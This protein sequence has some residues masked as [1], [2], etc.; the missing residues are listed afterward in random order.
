[1]SDVHASQLSFFTPFKYGH[2]L[3][4]KATGSRFGLCVTS[5]FK[6]PHFGVGDSCATAPRGPNLTT[7]S[8]QALAGGRLSQLPRLQGSFST[9]GPSK[10]EFAHPCAANCPILR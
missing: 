6:T 10:T 5:P 9:S 3:I 4:S 2:L 7:T 8:D 1:M